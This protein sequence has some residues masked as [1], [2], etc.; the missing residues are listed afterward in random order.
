MFCEKNAEN[1]QGKKE[2]KR[3]VCCSFFAL[4]S[5]PSTLKVFGLFSAS[6]LCRG[7]KIPETEARHF[8]WIY[9][10]LRNFNV[11]SKSTPNESVKLSQELLEVFLF[12]CNWLFTEHHILTKC[13]STI[14]NGN[15]WSVIKIV[16]ARLA[17]ILWKKKKP[18]FIQPV[19]I[20][21]MRL[22]AFV[23]QRVTFFFSFPFS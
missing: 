6:W 22:N 23:Q 3:E 18:K 13:P 8:S 14:P 11:F 20:F 15:I 19:S 17:Q 12:C 1:K 5:K 7:R 21:R 9:S 10:G 4:W 2:L 16:M